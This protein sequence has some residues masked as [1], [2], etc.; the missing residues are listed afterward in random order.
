MEPKFNLNRPKLSDEEINKHKNFDQLVKQFKQQSIDKAKHDKS[1]WKSKK[2]RYTAIIAGTLVICT[3]S[4]L[5]LFKNNYQILET[6]FFYLILF[7]LFLFQ[8]H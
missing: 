4:Y 1:W 3:I 6:V 7:R 8:K 5:D 2:V